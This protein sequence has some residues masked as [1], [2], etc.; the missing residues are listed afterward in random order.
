[1]GGVR[2]QISSRNAL[3]K[4]RQ[5]RVNGSLGDFAVPG[6]V[7][8]LGPSKKH[9]DSRHR[10]P[11]AGA[12]RQGPGWRHERHSAE[13]SLER[14]SGRMPRS[15]WVR[16]T[17][18]VRDGNIGRVLTNG[19]CSGL[20]TTALF[21]DGLEEVASVD[22]RRSPHPVMLNMRRRGVG[23]RVS[24]TGAAEVTSSQ[25]PKSLRMHRSGCGVVK[26]FMPSRVESLRAQ[27][28]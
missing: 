12:R 3:Q 8:G 14:G 11:K 17:S 23:S 5:T 7:S 13:R 25:C 15:V 22:T 27:T 19:S 18:H 10:R 24:T 21:T 16:K 9:R 6:F 4:Q 1:M 28:R 20:R 26:R 2:L